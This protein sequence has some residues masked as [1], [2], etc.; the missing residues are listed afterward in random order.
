MEK[1]AATQAKNDAFAAQAA[2]QA[3]T[4][5]LEQQRA[6]AAASD[7]LSRPQ[8][9]AEVQLGEDTPA[10][11][12]DPNTGRRRTARSSFRSPVRTSGIQI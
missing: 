6:A 10:A 11:E 8:E 4:T 1:Q 2:S 7:L 5:A 3:Q 9:Q 12:I